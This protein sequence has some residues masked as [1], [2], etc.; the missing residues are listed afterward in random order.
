MTA[1]GRDIAQ[2]LLWLI[3]VSFALASLARAFAG[4][5]TL[6]FITIHTPLNVESFTAV[7]F[8]LLILLRAPPG[9][10]VRSSLGTR[11]ETAGGLGLVILLCL[12]S[13]YHSLKAPLL[14]DDYG[15]VLLATHAGMH[16]FL[17]A[18]YIPHQDIFYRPLGFLSYAIDIHWAHFEAFRWH[19]WS[20]AVHTL[21]C[22]LVY[23]LIRQLAFSVWSAALGAMVFAVHGS[24]AE[25]VCWTDARFDLLSSFF[26]LLSLLCVGQY[27]RKGSYRWFTLALVPALAALFSKEAAY[28]LPFLVLSLTPFYPKQERRRLLKMAGTLAIVCA[29]QFAY[30]LWII[31]GVG[32]YQSGGRA[33]V[34]TFSA[35]RSLKALLWRLWALIF[36]PINWA[37]DTTRSVQIS[38]LIFVVAL[39]AIAFSTRANRLRLLGS[40]AL[41]VAASLPV[42]HLLL[43]ESDLAGAR[44]LYLPVLGLAVFWA[45][46]L[47]AHTAN[48]HGRYGIALAVLGFY[49]CCL[50]SNIAVWTRVAGMAQLACQSFG[51]T[52]AIGEGKVEVLALPVKHDGVF[53][54]SD[55]F[56][57]CVEMNSGVPANRVLIDTGETPSGTHR[58][59]RWNPKQLHFE[60]VT[61]SPR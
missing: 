49:L 55:A 44:L 51:Q 43:L 15:H 23:L 33:N 32:G 8:V 21:T 2:A 41:I 29:V 19:A 54:L 11:F 7:S 52:V 46:I 40:L 47:E 53:F 18:F 24:R 59:L 5:I 37:P 10:V 36:F 48:A 6:S 17:R 34:L 26:A 58:A 20:L 14:F 25:A 38:M 28:A 42:Q 22:G 45:T 27:T 35:L 1:R 9:S 12:F 61:S 56:P 13:F 39:G 31:G 3:F 57:D 16:D 60:P 50:E 30:R 4:E